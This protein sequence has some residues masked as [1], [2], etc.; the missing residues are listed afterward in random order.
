MRLQ[1]D[2]HLSTPQRGPEGKSRNSDT[3]TYE[4]HPQGVHTSRLIP[5]FHA[6]SLDNTELPGG[7]RR[8]IKTSVVET[9]CREASGVEC[10]CSSEEV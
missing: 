3:P 10:V 6:E 2:G 4:T 5:E 1:D 7:I 8:Q 9:V